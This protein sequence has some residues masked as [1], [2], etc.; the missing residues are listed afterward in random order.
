MAT[1]FV[2]KPIICEGIEDQP[3]V[4]TVITVRI[5]AFTG[6]ENARHSAPALSLTERSSACSSG[7]V[8]NSPSV[9]QSV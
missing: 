7:A 9:C 3:Q 6:V 5:V 8:S 1:L 2:I 4:L